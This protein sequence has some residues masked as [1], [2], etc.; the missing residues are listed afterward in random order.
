M[1]ET[2][3]IENP[4]SPDESRQGMRS[5]LRFSSDQSVAEV[6]IIWILVI[7][8]CFDFRISCFELA[9]SINQCLTHAGG[10]LFPKVAP[11]GSDTHYF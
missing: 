9:C 8:C 10:V 2:G 11:L 6:L 3:K 1:T 4:C 7:R 5:L